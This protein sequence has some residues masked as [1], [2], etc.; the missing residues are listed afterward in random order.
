MSERS[1][2]K[3]SVCSRRAYQTTQAVAQAGSQ[4]ASRFSPLRSE[5]A[6]F[7]GEPPRELLRSNSSFETEIL[8]NL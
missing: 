3:A 1:N 4:A 2:L 7:A 6:S 5:I 8:E